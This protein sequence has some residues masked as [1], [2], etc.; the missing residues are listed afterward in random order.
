L[1]IVQ[2]EDAS[3]VTSLLASRGFRSTRI[4]TAGG[5]SDGKT[6]AAA[7]AARS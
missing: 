6:S 5:V 7:Q 1:T 4:K 2:A 3:R